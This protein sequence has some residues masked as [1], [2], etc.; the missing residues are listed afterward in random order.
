[1]WAEKTSEDRG[2]LV[3]SAVGASGRT[4]QKKSGR[5]K[6][7]GD[8]DFCC[9]GEGGDLFQ[10]QGDLVERKVA[11]VNHYVKEYVPDRSHR[12]SKRKSRRQR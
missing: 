6:L 4:E 11:G 9:C 1:M 12:R 10:G 8:R 7:G 3:I 5:L 2:L